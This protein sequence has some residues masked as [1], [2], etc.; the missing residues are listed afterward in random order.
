MCVTSNFDPNHPL[1]RRV[2]RDFIKNAIFRRSTAREIDFPA[3][4]QQRKSISQPSITSYWRGHRSRRLQHFNLCHSAQLGTEQVDC[5]ILR[6]GRARQAEPP[7]ANPT[8]TATTDNKSIWI[9]RSMEPYPPTDVMV[10]TLHHYH[11]VGRFLV[12][13]FLHPHFQ[14]PSLPSTAHGS[15]K[16]DRGEHP[17][18][19]LSKLRVWSAQDFN[20]SLGVSPIACQ[21]HCFFRRDHLA[22]QNYK[23]Y[24]QTLTSPPSMHT[25]FWQRAS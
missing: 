8:P 16:R 11:H 5:C 23:M 24:L 7:T 18:S 19:M 12:R 9:D 22:E 3:P 4:T 14:P 25:T 17:N 21:P 1:Y 13:R 20:G 6:I 2:D 10:D 15:Q